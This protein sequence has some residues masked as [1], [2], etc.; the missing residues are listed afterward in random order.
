[1]T[2]RRFCNRCGQPTA[3]ITPDGDHLPRHVCQHCGIVHYENPRVVVG[4]VPEHA[5]HILICRR[6][7]DPRRGYRTIPAG[8]LEN[9]DTLEAARANATR[10]RWPPRSAAAGDQHPEG[11]RCFF[12]LTSCWMALASDTKALNG[13]GTPADPRRDRLPPTHSLS[14]SWRRATGSERHA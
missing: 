4:C 13:P 8:F 1:M 3:F 7:I 10:R 11:T 9:D 2:E 12:F 14:S 6:A 5:G